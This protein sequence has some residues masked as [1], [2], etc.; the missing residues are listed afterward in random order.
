MPRGVSRFL[1]SQATLVTP[2]HDVPLHQAL[3]YL[4]VVAVISMCTSG[5]T[6][7]LLQYCKPSIVRGSHVLFSHLH[8][9]PVVVLNRDTFFLTAHLNYSVS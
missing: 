1:P 3:G 9:I 7:V 5:L 6:Q 8:G 4:A 2:R